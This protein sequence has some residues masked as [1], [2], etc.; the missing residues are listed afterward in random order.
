VSD[1]TDTRALARAIFDSVPFLAWLGI[2]VT[3][4]S[5]EG[6]VARF[7]AREEL[8]GNPHQRILHGG[9]ISAVMDSVGGLV[10]IL[11][12]IE[13]LGED[14]VGEEASERVMK[15][16]TIDMRA[17]FLSPGRGTEFVCEGHVLRLGRHVVVS[18]ME[19]RNEE[20]TLIAVGTGSYNY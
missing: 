8:I 20:G 18:R 7:R 13:S 10:G 5:P 6:V 9:V 12:Y 14:G 15:L 17:D 11:K 3:E 4:A 19:F 16:A 2:E 1:R